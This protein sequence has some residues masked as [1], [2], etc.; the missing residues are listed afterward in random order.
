MFYTDCDFHNKL[1][2]TRINMKLKSTIK[3]QQN[4]LYTEIIM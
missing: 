2:L 4:N 1:R 3:L